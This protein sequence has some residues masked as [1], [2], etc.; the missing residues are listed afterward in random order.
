MI[1]G[2]IEWVIIMNCKQEKKLNI[3]LVAAV[4]AM[5][6]K[7]LPVVSSLAN[8][9]RVIMD[10]FPNT[11]WSGFYLTDE[12]GEFLYLGPFQGSTATVKIPFG[13]GVCG[14]GAK[15]KQSQLVPNVHQFEGHI[16]CSL[17]SN[18][19]VV[20]PIINDDKVVGVIDLDSNLYDNYTESD[21]LLLEEVAKVIAELF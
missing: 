7:E 17:S 6:I 4:R 10:Y 18:S 13:K 2:I 21:V 14:V 20:V 15:S 9:S 8:I 19:E 5:C 1:Y 3:N 16:A 11:D 12:T